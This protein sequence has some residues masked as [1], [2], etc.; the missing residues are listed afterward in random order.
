MSILQN[1]LRELDQHEQTADELAARRWLRDLQMTRGGD[2]KGN[3]ANIVHA[4]ENAPQLRGVVAYEEF[5]RRQVM[6]RRAPWEPGAFLQ[7]AWRDS[8][9][10]ELLTWLQQNGVPATATSTVADA[11]RLVAERHKFDA[12]ADF[13]NG[14]EWD[15][16]ERLSW[17]LE[18]YLDAEP[19]ELTQAIGRAWLIS[20]VARG[21]QPGCQADH[22]LVLE[23]AQ[24]A[25]KSTAARIIGGDFTQEHLP[26]LHS[27]DAEAGLAGSWIV[28][29]SELAAMSRSE[30]ESVKSFLTRRVDRYRPAYGRHMVEQPRRCVF[31]A[32]TNEQKYL[33][34]T[35]GNRR[36][37]PVEVGRADLDALAD[38]RDQLLAEAVAA[39]KAGEA[40]HLT[41]PEL[42]H[43]A[44]VEQ[45]RRQEEEPWL[46]LIASYL[47]G[48][49]ETS[50]RALLDR[51]EIPDDKRAAGHAKR[52]G[53]IMR[54]LG[55]TRRI[56]KSGG[57]RE[58][59]WTR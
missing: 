19:S 4:L 30:A 6:M 14:L 47:E 35:S 39:F 36:F 44:Q 25:G 43:A 49:S 15:G 42:V 28:E 50:T 53:G 54:Q 27:K 8:D 21:L 51:L 1:A 33:R 22:V 59:I 41:D 3:L 20:A 29:L 37:W 58:A 12:L 55:W 57:N 23:G 16:R 5:T 24:G 13:L 26:D 10:G 11:V 32:T 46:D 45:A 52:L 17:W 31:L 9:D 38:N 2:A 18:L 48:R 56:D 7:R 40:W 34:D